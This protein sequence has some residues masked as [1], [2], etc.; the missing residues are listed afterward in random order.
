MKVLVSLLT[1][2]KSKMIAKIRKLETSTS[3]TCMKNTNFQMIKDNG[4]SLEEKSSRSSM[5]QTQQVPQISKK[6]KNIS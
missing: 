5:L 3:K 4:T 1:A 2:F 6:V